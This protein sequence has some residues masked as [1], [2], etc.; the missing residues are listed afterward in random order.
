MSSSEIQL[1]QQSSK[2]CIE[3]YVDRE[4]KVLQTATCQQALID[5]A[6]TLKKMN[7]GGALDLAIKLTRSEAEKLK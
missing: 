2:S 1:I 3:A 7:I 6:D 4:L 5:R